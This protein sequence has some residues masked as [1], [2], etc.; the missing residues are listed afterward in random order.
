MGSKEGKEACLVYSS[1]GRGVSL[2]YSILI[3][4]LSLSLGSNV[5]WKWCRHL[6]GFSPSVYWSVGVKVF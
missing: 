2:A 4:S 5:L 6:P 1:E 3:F